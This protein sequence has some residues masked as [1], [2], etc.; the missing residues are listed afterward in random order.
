M[1]KYLMGEAAHENTVSGQLTHITGA[2]L[3]HLGSYAVLLHQRFLKSW[4][5]NT[6]TIVFAIQT[7]ATPNA[8]S[9]N[10]A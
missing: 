10:I 2:Q 1:I 7:W 8:L 5:V 6:C 9:K 4:H 3:P